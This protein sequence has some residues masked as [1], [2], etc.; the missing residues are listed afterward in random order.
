MNSRSKGVRGELEV[1]KILKEW[2]APIAPDAEW[3]RTPCSGGWGGHCETN[4]R[5][6][7]ELKAS[8]DIMCTYPDFP[9]CVEVKRG[10]SW[11]LTRLINCRSSPVWKWW[12]QC[13]REAEEIHRVPMLWFR[14]NRESWYVMIPLEFATHVRGIGSPF[15]AFL[16][17]EMQKLDF[18]Y[19]LPSLYSSETVLAVPPHRM[20]EAWATDRSILKLIK[21]TSREKAEL[22]S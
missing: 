22:D 20:L 7:A 12:R 10:E 8:G 5:A 6:R 19:H 4:Q 1:A 11:S 14:H 21:R 18:G 2:F 9:F 17:A 3:V 16:Y 15:R 13:Q